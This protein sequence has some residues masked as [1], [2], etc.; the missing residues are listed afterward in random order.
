MEQDI[1]QLASDFF[2]GRISGKL[3][4]SDT[5]PTDSAAEDAAIHAVS[6]GAGQFQAGRFT[7]L[8]FAPDIDN[9]S[10]R[11]LPDKARLAEMAGWAPELLAHM[12]KKTQEYVLTHGEN[13]VTQGRYPDAKEHFVALR[14]NLQRESI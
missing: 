9:G 3:Y 13:P 14:Y 7:I 10:G 4:L 11:L 5:R 1:Y 12:R 8:V 6:I 2:E